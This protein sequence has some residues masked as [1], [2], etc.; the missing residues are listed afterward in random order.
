MPP[1]DM[2]VLPFGLTKYIGEPLILFQE[3]DDMFK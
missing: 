2:S 3:R 1:S